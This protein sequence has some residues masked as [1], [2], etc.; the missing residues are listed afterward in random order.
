MLSL[1]KVNKMNL[2]IQGCTA[3]MAASGKTS[4]NL[5]D[6]PL[7]N[8]RI[9]K[10][11][12]RSYGSSIEPDMAFDATDLLALPG[13]VDLH[14]DAFERQ[15]QPRPG[16]AFDFG[17]AL[18][19]T[20]RQLVGNGITTAFHGITF[21][22]EGGLRGGETAMRLMESI[23]TQR[24][25][26]A[27]DHRVHL[28]FENHH[29]DGVEIALGW[30]NKGWVD[31]LAFND[32]LPSIERKSQQPGMLSSYAERGRCDTATFAAR[33]AAAK[34]GSRKVDEVIEV[35]AAACRAHAVPMASHDDDSQIARRKYQT[36]GV[37]ICEFPKN[38]ETLA[39]ARR[40]GNPVVLGAPNVLQIGSHSGGLN[41]AEIVRRR[42]CDILTSD[43]YYPSLLH[44]A[45]KLAHELDACSLSSAWRL[46]SANPAKAMGLHDRGDIAEGKRADLLL[47]QPALNGNVR[48]VATIAA[49]KLVYCAEPDRL[50]PASSFPIAA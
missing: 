27:A 11:V 1:K 17:I 21:S 19:D 4:W 2:L 13:I 16:T 45:F 39:A 32:H 44:A 46:V 12:T 20:D 40:L 28:R 37:H 41:A 31:L 35:L 42:E 26:F 15:I 10:A 48:L 14:G 24:S 29:V 34:A 5:T 49:G 3:L 23:R 9:E 25:W 8:G 50:N 6:L 38:E 18:C 22:W 33:L 36:L 43:Y 30:I 7:N 47:V